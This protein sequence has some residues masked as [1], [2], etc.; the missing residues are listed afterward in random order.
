[1]LEFVIKHMEK[2]IAHSYFNI[3]NNILY[4]CMFLFPQ[5][6][7]LSYNNLNIFVIL[8]LQLG[9]LETAVELLFPVEICSEFVIKQPNATPIIP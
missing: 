7:N 3:N 4:L 8:T 6:K 1:M 2:Q 9:K 5:S